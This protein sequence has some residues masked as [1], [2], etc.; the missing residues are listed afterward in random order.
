MSLV[1][2]MLIGTGC[3][4]LSAPEDDSTKKSSPDITIPSPASNTN[5]PRGGSSVGTTRVQKTMADINFPHRTKIDFTR[6]VNFKIESYDPTKFGNHEPFV[7]RQAGI[8][9][10]VLFGRSIKDSIGKSFSAEVSAGR[11]YL[12]LEYK[13]D[14]EL[15]EEIFEVGSGGLSVVEI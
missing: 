9:R 6:R 11:V 14:G 4:Q 3:I 7:V 15:T 2:I 5:S 12:V 1:A 13:V 8:D 10:P